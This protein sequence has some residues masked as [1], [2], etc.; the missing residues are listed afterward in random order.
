MK[1]TTINYSEAEFANLKTLKKDMTIFIPKGQTT[2]LALQTYA[3][4]LRLQAAKL[5]R[6]ADFVDQAVNE[7]CPKV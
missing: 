1:I 5:I 3:D 6:D 2:A 7:L 4:E